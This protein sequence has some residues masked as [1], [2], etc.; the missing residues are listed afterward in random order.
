[1]L[2]PASVAGTNAVV[3][4][5]A[6]NRFA[7]GDSTPSDTGLAVFQ[8]KTVVSFGPMT[9]NVAEIGMVTQRWSRVMIPRSTDHAPPGVLGWLLGKA[10]T[11][12]A[13]QGPGAQLPFMTRRVTLLFGSSDDE[14]ERAATI[15]GGIAIKRRRRMLSP[16]S[17]VRLKRVKRRGNSHRSAFSISCSAESS[18][19]KTSDARVISQ[20]YGNDASR[21]CDGRRDERWGGHAWA[22]SRDHHLQV[23][24]RPVRARSTRWCPCQWFSVF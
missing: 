11:S 10:R 17:P 15:S 2:H 19:A 9:R 5:K 7:D 13:L 16:V 18:S 3:L 4:G 1:M 21:R 6:I 14:Q 20:G 24:G 22:T 23:L 8:L 12:W